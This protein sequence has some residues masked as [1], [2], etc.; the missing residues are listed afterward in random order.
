MVPSVG[1]SLGIWLCEWLEHSQLSRKLT[2][3]EIFGV[4]FGLGLPVS[5]YW[6]EEPGP[7]Y[8]ARVI[9]T[10]ALH[11]LIDIGILWIPIP[12]INGLGMPR[13]YRH[14]VF[15]VFFLGLL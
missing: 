3:R 12:W 7:R 1:R 6:T 10:T 4:I 2:K 13:L 15:G 8:W 5:R 14:L 11:I 9:C